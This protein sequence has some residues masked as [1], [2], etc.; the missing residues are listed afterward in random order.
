MS[1][2]AEHRAHP[3]YALEIDCELRTP[4]G[5][6][7]ARSRDVSGGGLAFTTKQA[8]P[9][10]LDA[11]INMSLVFDEQTFSEPLL[12][13]ARIVWCTGLAADRY[14]VGATF[15][16]MTNEQRAYLEM[17]LR[18]LREG[19]ARQKEAIAESTEPEDET[20]G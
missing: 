2:T 16:G 10:G 4:G 5:V 13:R 15:V 19:Q 17:F 8:V 18:Y 1:K 12:V 20:F 6:I 7:P 11:Q 3:R 9:L 14:Q